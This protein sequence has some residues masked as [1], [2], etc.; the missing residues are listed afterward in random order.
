MIYY[1]TEINFINEN[2]LKIFQKKILKNIMLHIGDGARYIPS[3]LNI[4]CLILFANSKESIYKIVSIIYNHLQNIIKTKTKDTDSKIFNEILYKYNINLNFGSKFLFDQIF[5]NIKLSYNLNKLTYKSNVINFSKANKSELSNEIIFSSDSI[6]GLC[7]YI[8]Y[9]QTS[10]N[11]ILKNEPFPDNF[12]GTNLN[13][14]FLFFKN[15]VLRIAS[16]IPTLKELEWIN[17]SFDSIFKYEIFRNIMEN[18]KFLK[19]NYTNKKVSYNII[20]P[21]DDLYDENEEMLNNIIKDYIINYPKYDIKNLV[22][23]ET[24]VNSISQKINFN[25]SADEWYPNK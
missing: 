11:N 2:I 4:H 21:E 7:G 16:C 19:I 18:S 25:A 5:P 3:H 8:F 22:I 24:V 9:I 6:D 14:H 15:K 10:I 17:N 12:Y 1:S 13:L 23:N 20:N